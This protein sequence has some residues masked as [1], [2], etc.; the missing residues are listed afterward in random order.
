MVMLQT[1]V[2]MDVLQLI[3]QFR[4]HVTEP[5]QVIFKPSS[6]PL[7]IIKRVVLIMT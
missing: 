4:E 7:V 6:V 3:I 1:D 5:V 2:K